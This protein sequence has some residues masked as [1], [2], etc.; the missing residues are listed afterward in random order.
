MTCIG[1]HD[2]GETMKPGRS[3]VTTMLWTSSGMP[4]RIVGIGS[5]ITVAW[6]ST[7]SMVSA[8]RTTTV[9]R[10]NGPACAGTTIDSEYGAPLYGPARY[11][12]VGALPA[13]GTDSGMVPTPAAIVVVPTCE[14]AEHVP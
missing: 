13:C 10:S 2:V 11:T 8:A 4:W 12:A 1:S 9:P 3:I 5:E 6:A 7:G 14:A